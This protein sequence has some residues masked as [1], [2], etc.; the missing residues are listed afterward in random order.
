MGLTILCHVST[1]RTILPTALCLATKCILAILHGQ[2]SKVTNQDVVSTA[3]A[4]IPSNRLLIMFFI[5]MAMTTTLLIST[6]S[7]FYSNKQNKK[8]VLMKLWVKHDIVP[9]LLGKWL[10]VFWRSRVPSSIGVIQS[11][12]IS[13]PGLHHSY[14][15]SALERSEWS[16]PCP[17]NFT[18]S[19]QPLGTHS[20]KHIYSIIVFGFTD[21]SLTRSEQV[22]SHR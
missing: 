8:T 15:N 1:V 12:K 9:L 19:K 10:P 3:V 11:N 16:A 14:L 20:N 6:F 17:T 5:W 4:T 7:I 13:L 18:P 21:N 22:L 2:L